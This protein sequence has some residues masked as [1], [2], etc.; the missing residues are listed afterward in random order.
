MTQL[1]INNIT[2]PETS[3]DK[4]RCY[5]AELSVKADMISGRRVSEVRGNVQMIS[6]QYDYL[7]AALWRSLAAVLRAGTAMTVQY[8]PDD[9]DELITST[10]LRDGMTEPSFAF[11]RHG[12]PYWHG[13]AFTLREVNPHD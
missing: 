2:L 10:F 3:H 8:L 7:P 1:I 12:L 5:P 4:Y 11:S 6:Y 13:L 9:S